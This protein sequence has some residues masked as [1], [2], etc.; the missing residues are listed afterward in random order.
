MGQEISKE[1]VNIECLSW[2]AEISISEAAE[3]III[4]KIVF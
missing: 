1:V 4:D 3:E 2:K